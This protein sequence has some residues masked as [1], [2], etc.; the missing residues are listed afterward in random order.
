MRTSVG[1]DRTIKAQLNKIVLIPSITF[2]ALFAV[3]SGGALTQAISLRLAAGDSRSGLHA[4][5][6][7][8]ELQK[9][10]RLAAEHLGAP[11]E[12]SLR[13]LDRQTAITDSAVR[14]V[15][16]RREGLRGRGRGDGAAVDTARDFLS[17]LD[18][19]E[20]LR[21]HVAEGST[22]VADTVAGYAEII[23]PGIRAYNALGRLLDDGPAATAS[24]DAADLMQAQEN[25]TLADA[26]L[27]GAAG[28]E[29]LTPGQQGRVGGITEHA[30]Q[31]IEALGP[32]L[33]GNTARLHA[34]LVDSAHWAKLHELA[35]DVAKHDL[36]DGP[37]PGLGQWRSVADDTS[38]DLAALADSQANNVIYATDAASAEMFTLA[39]AGG[40]IVLFAS[41]VAYG[42]ASKSAAWLTH[43]LARLR[44]ETLELSREE[45]P[46]LV[47]RLENGEQVDPDAELRQLDHGTDEVGQV[48]DAFNIAQRTAVAAAV[49]QAEVRDGANRVFLGIA[50]RNQSLVQRQLQV[51][52]RVEREAED[53]DLLEDLFQL[54]HLATRGR[55][56]AENLIILGGQQP[57]RRWRAP[58]PLVDILRGAISE[59]EEYARVKLRVVPDLSLPGSVVADVLHLLAELVENATAF[60][61]PHTK[62]YIHGE[63]VAKGL[64]VEVEDRGLGMREQ[65]LVEANRRLIEAPEFDVMAL[66]QDARLGLF[67]VARLANKHGIHVELR[68]SPYGGT[69]AI[70][71]I[72]AVLVS[73]GGPPATTRP[74][75]ELNA[76]V[77]APD[78]LS[79]RKPAGGGQANG[80]PAAELADAGDRGPWNNGGSASTGGTAPKAGSADRDGLPK[81]SPGSSLCPRSGAAASAPEQGSDR[82]RLPK[83]QRQANLAPQLRDA[84]TQE[85]TGDAASE[86]EKRPDEVRQMFSA[87]QTGTQRG[88]DN[89]DSLDRG[90]SERSGDASSAGGAAGAVPRVEKA[91]GE[92]VPGTFSDGG[93]GFRAER[94]DDRD[95]NSPGPLPGAPACTTGVRDGHAGQA[96]GEREGESE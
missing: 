55:R 44:A 32:A 68:P 90:P 31:R 91:G 18:D 13:A 35:R 7:V 50:H 67:V 8:A 12:E 27:S 63:T 88:R 34:D 45:L 66:N 96:A 19:R 10:R 41:T 73:R 70:V 71:L 53:P 65:G 21:E 6:A 56:N 42:V 93:N 69:R 3:L 74:Q 28:K 23:K 5:Y 58:I 11:S 43:R 83:R 86:R 46:R 29:M 36:E 15:E 52:D 51:L 47:R 82:P 61:P 62:V 89:E 22:T 94:A 17:A 87:F 80:A 48:A 49:K 95:M 37:P 39:L 16:S 14:E 60:S 38:A 33:H 40:I 57:G 85:C 76:G 2:L 72:P 4:Y 84:A 54:D 59:T 81:R 30:R 24:A 78:L 9:E 77:G 75:A 79:E 1:A 92:R 26:L 25:L 20:H 64:V